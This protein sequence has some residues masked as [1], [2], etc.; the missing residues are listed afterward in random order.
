M[1]SIHGGDS[2]QISQVLHQIAIQISEDSNP[3]GAIQAVTQIFAQLTLDAQAPV[4][5]ALFQLAQQQ[6]SGQNIEQAI[7]QVGQQVAQGGDVTQAIVQAAGQSAQPQGGGINLTSAP[8][9]NANSHTGGP[10]NQCGPRAG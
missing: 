3:A 5:Q 10:R 7:V 8:R 9:N 4:S 1:S 6:A 2:A